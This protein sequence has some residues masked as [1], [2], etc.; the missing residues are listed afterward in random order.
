M[1]LRT[2]VFVITDYILIAQNRG[3]RHPC[4]EIY[5]GESTITGCMDIPLRITATDIG[6][7]RQGTQ[8][9]M[10]T[11]ISHDKKFAS[12]IYFPKCSSR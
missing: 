7:L 2:N 8:T 12:R 11:Y 1:I 3:S 4:I 6:R 10:N 9:D 5:K